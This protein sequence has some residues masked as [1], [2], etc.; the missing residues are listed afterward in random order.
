MATRRHQSTRPRRTKS[1]GY[2]ESLRWDSVVWGS[3]CV[4]CYPGNCPFR[5][6]VR[7]GSDRREE[8]AGTCHRS[9][10]ACPT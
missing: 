2:P 1:N 5:V 7:D 6:Y 8:Q 9:S 4:D 3:H 10:R